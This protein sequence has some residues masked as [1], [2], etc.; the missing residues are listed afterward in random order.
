MEKLEIVPNDVIEFNCQDKS[1]KVLSHIVLTNHNDYKM[2]FKLMTT[3][4]S[5]FMVKPGIGVINPQSKTDISIALVSDFTRVKEIESQRF[6]LMIFDYNDNWNEEQ[7]ADLIKTKK[8][9]VHQIKLRV[10]LNTGEERPAHRDT[11][12]GSIAAGSLADPIFQSSMMDMKE[13]EHRESVPNQTKVAEQRIDDPIQRPG[14]IIGVK[15][16][17]QIDQARQVGHQIERQ[18]EQ[19]QQSNLDY[20]GTRETEVLQD[21]ERQIQQLQ[22]DKRRLEAEL[23]RMRAESIGART[24][25]SVAVKGKPYQTWQIILVLIIAIFFGY[26]LGTK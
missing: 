3:S 25:Q 15:P 1:Q 24:V 5:T 21:K 22:E 2:G 23:G 26:F 11:G 13:I 20:F 7:L 17:P 14:S 19:I 12:E 9:K 6:A 8:E 4:Q 18:F 16:A 10:K